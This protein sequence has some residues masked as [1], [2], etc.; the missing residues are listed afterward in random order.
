MI[1]VDLALAVT[2]GM[3]FTVNPCGFAMLPAYLS[4]F[5]GVEQGADVAADARAS[6]ARALAV[7]IAVTVGFATSYALLGLVVSR[8][9]DG[10][11]DVAPWVSV[12]IGLA[13]V[14]FG[15][16]LLAGYS[17]NLRTPHLD[18]GGRTRG[19]GSMVLFGVSYA[20]ASLGCTLGLFL[21]VMSTNFGRGFASGI[22]YF[23]A[24]AAGFF[25]VVASLTVAIALA[26]HSLV[27]T[28]RRVLPF[29][30][31]IAGGL[32]VLT[33]AYVAWYGVV[34]IRTP[35]SSDGVVDRVTLWSSDAS[36]WVQR[37]GGTTIALVLS[38]VIT[39][40]AAFVFFSRRG[41]RTSS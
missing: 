40:A 7:A 10:V 38:T 23:S 26:E 24:F 20:V 29:V 36:D 34:S 31:R 17:P 4:F 14:C 13:L 33:G 22:A 15:I 28:V 18:K 32:L 8:L 30:N 16:A 9:T 27:R 1:D 5:V 35:T 41:A 19:F 11:Y 12:L 39:A 3:V 6:V 21:G 25:L 37:T 2:T